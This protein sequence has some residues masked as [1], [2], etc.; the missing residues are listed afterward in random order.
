[1]HAEVFGPFAFGHPADGAFDRD[2]RSVIDIGDAVFEFER[3]ARH[4]GRL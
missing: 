3:I 4:V 1:M 2:D